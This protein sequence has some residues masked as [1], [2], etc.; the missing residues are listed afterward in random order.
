MLSP[1]LFTHKNE[2]FRRSTMRTA[3]KEHKPLL[4]RGNT[5][6]GDLIHTFTLP[7]MSTCPGATFAC[8]L[9]CYAL[10]FARYA[11]SSLARHADNWE[12][13]K[14]LA[15]FEKAMVVE[16]RFRA[17]QVLRI[18]V[19]GDFHSVAYTKAWTRIAQRCP[20]TTFLFYTR[21]WR[22]P[23]IATALVELATLPNV[24][25]WW[26]EDRDSGPGPL[27]GGRRCF[28]CVEAGDE[29]LVPEGVDLVFREKTKSP[30][31]WIGASWVCPKE[32]G[33]GARITCS[34][35]RRCFLPG[36]MPSRRDAPSA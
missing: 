9:V 31:K 34:T 21:S 12:R 24:A 26:S 7:A 3:T 20:T 25:A 10:G 14:S 32:Q 30:R 1:S 18:H 22:V 29:A 4:Q 16:I 33:T 6:L 27:P 23:E 17:V 15:E 2:F 19:G 35:C 28:L 8:L 13:A 11:R 36:P 5:H